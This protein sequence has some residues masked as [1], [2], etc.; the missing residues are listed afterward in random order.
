MT[1]PVEPYFQRPEISVPTVSGAAMQERNKSATASAVTHKF[2]VFRKV[3]FRAVARQ[4]NALPV[5][6]VMSIRSREV[7]SNATK[8]ELRAGNSIA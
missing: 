6:A 1:Q 3:G 8:L 7:D 4:M 5:I 2:V